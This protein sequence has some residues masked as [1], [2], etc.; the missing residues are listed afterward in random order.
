V[1]TR[2]ANAWEKGDLGTIADY[3]SWCDCVRDEQEREFLRRMND[4]RNPHLA[5]GIDALHLNG[6]RVFAAV[7]ALHMVGEKSLP[8][9]L[10][11]RGY[12]IERIE[13]R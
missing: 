1:L 8:K 12:A 2:L 11:A 5:S 4:E 13:L 7:G 10:A 6:A 3:E 9:L